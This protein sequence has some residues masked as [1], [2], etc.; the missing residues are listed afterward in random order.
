MVGAPSCPQAIALRARI[1]RLAADGLANSAIAAEPRGPAGGP[2]DHA[3]GRSCGGLP[4]KM[5]LAFRLTPGQAD[6]A[7]AFGTAGDEGGPEASSPSPVPERGGGG[8]AARCQR[9]AYGRVMISM[10]W[11]SG[12]AKYAPRPPKRW[13][14]WPASVRLGSA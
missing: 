14:I 9:R 4:I 8:E 5:H 12:S 10:L 11:R 3:L 1:V 7:L 2:H 6:D 13:L